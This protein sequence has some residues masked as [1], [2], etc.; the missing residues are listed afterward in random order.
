[1]FVLQE[2]RKHRLSCPSFGRMAAT[3]LG[4]PGLTTRSKNATSNK[5]RLVAKGIAT[6]GA[7]TLLGSSWP[8]GGNAG[9]GAFAHGV[10]PS[11][12]VAGSDRA[13]LGRTSESETES[14]RRSSQG[15]CDACANDLHHNPFTELPSQL[16]SID[17]SLPNCLPSNHSV[18]VLSSP[19]TWKSRLCDGAH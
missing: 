18:L 4:A 11:L 14:G 8:H 12:R 15:P 6:N 16:A 7:R 9:G 10:R 17:P 1:M 19:H 2:G 13:V 5:K 3:L